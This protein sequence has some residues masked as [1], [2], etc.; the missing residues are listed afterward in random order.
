MQ[1]QVSKIDV[2]SGAKVQVYQWTPDGEVRGLIHVLHGLA[3]HAG[4]YERL[5]ESLTARGLAVVAHDHRGH[6][7][8]APTEDDLGVFADEDGWRVVVD[9]AAAV[10]RWAKE[11]FPGVPTAMFGHSM[12][13]SIGLAYLGWHP[14][15]VD[16]AVLSGPVGKAPPLRHVGMMVAKVESALMGERR[17]SWLLDKMSFG[18]FNKPFRPNRTAFDWLSRDPLE[19]DKYVAD[20]HCGFLVSTSMWKDILGGIGTYM[21]PAHMSRFDK[22]LPIFVFAGEEDPVGGQGQ[23]VRAYLGMLEDA[24]IRR[25]DQRFYA[26]ARHECL[27]ET[28][29]DEVMRDVGTWLESA[30]SLEG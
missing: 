15:L 23:A 11:A 9:D 29:R 7:L 4:R 20:P 27:N 8:T 24:G 10:T 3:E 25:L 17:K 13:S 22:D 1:T 6:G 28:N 18:D 26:G 5:A 16:A 21:D 12:G 2:P 19:V 30:L 14:G